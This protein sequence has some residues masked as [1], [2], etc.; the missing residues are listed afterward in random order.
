MH[1]P[2]HPLIS[3]PPAERMIFA[4]VANVSISSLNLSLLVNTVGFYQARL[5][6]LHNMQTRLPGSRQLALGP[7]PNTTDVAV[8][9]DARR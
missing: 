4:V 9:C 7:P 5:A 8:G 2:A 1:H 3:S 6:Q